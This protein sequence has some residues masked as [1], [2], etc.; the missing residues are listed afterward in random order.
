MLKRQVLV[1]VLG[2][3][4]TTGLS[5]DLDLVSIIGIDGTARIRI[6]MSQTNWLY[7]KNGSVRNIKDSSAMFTP[8]EMKTVVK[9]E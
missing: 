6:K 9:E 7:I 8:I 5:V 3:I 1:T 4:G 2:V